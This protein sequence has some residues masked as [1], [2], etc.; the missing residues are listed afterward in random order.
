V[1]ETE[2]ADL[3]TSLRKALDIAERLLQAVKA[4]GENPWVA[5]TLGKQLEYQT[6]PLLKGLAMGEDTLGSVPNL[7]RTA[8]FNTPSG[9]SASNR[10]GYPIK[11]SAPEERRPAFLKVT[12]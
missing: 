11:E 8:E 6:V 7:R 2:I 5:A 10:R 1:Y 3:E 12:R 4:P 9:A